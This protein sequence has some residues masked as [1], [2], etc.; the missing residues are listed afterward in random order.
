MYK[1]DLLEIDFNLDVYDPD[2]ID[3]VTVWVHGKNEVIGVIK[4]ASGA[5]REYG[6][7]VISY[8]MFGTT[9]A[10]AHFPADTVT[11]LSVIVEHKQERRTSRDHNS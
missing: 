7:W 5:Y 8:K 1:D 6:L 3:S 11:Y 9:E 4:H 2:D 10:V